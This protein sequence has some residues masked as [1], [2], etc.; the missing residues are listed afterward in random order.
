MTVLRLCRPQ[1]AQRQHDHPARRLAAL[2]GLLLILETGCSGSHAEPAPAPTNAPAAV[3]DEQFCHGGLPY[4][5]TNPPYS[6]KGPHTAGIIVPREKNS[7][8]I[9]AA[10]PTLPTGWTPRYN[11]RGPLNARAPE[12][13]VCMKL[14]QSVKRPIIGKCEYRNPDGGSVT[15]DVVAASYEF[16]VFAASTG[17]SLTTFQLRATGKASCP[18]SVA[19]GSRADFSGSLDDRQ[20]AARLRSLISRTA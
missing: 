4:S 19:T 7:L 20:F 17:Q 1:A 16:T 10:A 15:Y 2:L 8:V 5:H 11:A 6:G 9:A 12:L 14:L 3:N 18:A 13:L